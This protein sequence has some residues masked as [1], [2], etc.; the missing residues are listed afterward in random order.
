MDIRSAIVI[1][2]FSL[3]LLIYTYQRLGQRRRG[4]VRSS[5]PPD[6]WR[7]STAYWRAW[8]RTDTVSALRTASIAGFL[9]GE[10]VREIHAAG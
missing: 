5:H 7:G 1:G 6:S 3:L 10:V 2:A 8:E 4:E 9:R